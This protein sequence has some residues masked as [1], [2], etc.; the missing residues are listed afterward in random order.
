[1]RKSQDYDLWLRISEKSKIGCI[2]YIGTHI[3][4]HSNN[5][6]FKLSSNENY[7]S[8]NSALSISDNIGKFNKFSLSYDITNDR[9]NNEIY[10]TQGSLNSLYI[11]VAPDIFSDINYYRVSVKNNFYIK[12]KNSDSNFFMLSSKPSI[13]VLCPVTLLLSK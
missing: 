12:Q 10:P 3:R 8:K 13:S 2:C 5:I 6:S 7:D 11:E 9:L 4:V 1:M